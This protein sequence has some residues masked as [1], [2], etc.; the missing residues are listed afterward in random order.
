MSSCREWRKK[1]HGACSLICRS[2]PPR[3][4]RWYLIYATCFMFFF[5][6]IHDDDN[7]GAKRTCRWEDTFQTTGS[8]SIEIFDHRYFP[9]LSSDASSCLTELLEEFVNDTRAGV[10]VLFEPRPHQFMEPVIR[11]MKERMPDSWKI[12]VLTGPTSISL[13]TSIFKEEI[14]VGKLILTNVGGDDVTWLGH[15]AHNI[16]PYNRILF[17]P[18]FWDRLLHENIL[19]VHAD[20]WI[21]IN[22]TD[23]IY[24]WLKYDYV[25]APWNYSP[26]G[27]HRVGNGGFSLRKR[28]A[29]K[30]VISFFAEQGMGPADVFIERNEDEVFG[31]VIYNDLSG[32]VPSEEDAT[33]FAVCGKYYD[34]PWAIHAYWKYLTF[35]ESKQMQQ[36]C[37]NPQWDGKP[38]NGT[39]HW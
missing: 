34:K 33:R 7:H 38:W 31:N 35:E 3:K 27:G 5:Y 8:G 1:T 18:A 21:C 4:I 26:P 2:G 28:T 36:W 6:T 29:M 12:Q 23:S 14:S 37:Q 30:N 17:S 39:K 20:A 25:G 15:H 11:N 10:V 9:P 32:L 19:L 22:T 13:L 24:Q 16:L